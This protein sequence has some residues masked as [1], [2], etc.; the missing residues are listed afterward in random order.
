M[1]PASA[2]GS[3][4]MDEPLTSQEVAAITRFTPRWVRQK[5]AA[6]TIPGAIQVDVGGEWRFD[7][8]RFFK[9]WNSKERTPCLRTYGVRSGGSGSN[10]RMRPSGSRLEQVIA[11]GRKR[12]KENSGRRTGR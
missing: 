1:F 11:A 2:P 8:K 12:L 5:A 7:R 4:P 9:W 3:I 6:G 10:G